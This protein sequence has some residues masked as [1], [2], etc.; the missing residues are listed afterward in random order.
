MSHA[1]L[2]LSSC[3]FAAFV[4]P[5]VEVLRNADT[6]GYLVHGATWR[7]GSSRRGFGGRQVDYITPHLQVR[8]LAPK[9]SSVANISA[10]TLSRSIDLYL[11]VLDAG[12]AQPL[13]RAM[14]NDILQA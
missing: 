2:S 13:Q 14:L 8:M 11:Y 5:L 1:S 6:S 12:C 3:T 7:E 9:R 10:G 4:F